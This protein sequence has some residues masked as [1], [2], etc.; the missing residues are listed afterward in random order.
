MQL[1][2]VQ[3]DEHELVKLNCSIAIEVYF[4]IELHGIELCKLLSKEGL[5]ASYKF[6]FGKRAIHVH[7][8]LL[9]DTAVVLSFLL[10]QKLRGDES[11]NSLS[12]LGLV[13]E[14]QQATHNMI[15]LLR[16]TLM[17]QLLFSNFLDPV[18]LQGLHCRRS[19]LIVIS[20]QVRDEIL[21]F[22]G[23]ILPN[24]ILEVILSYLYLF[25]YL[26]IARI[27]ERRSPAK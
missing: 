15:H 20:E 26:F 4:S 16:Q 18:M 25:H 1:V 13:P 10:G 11:V 22:I 23:N 9:E 27:I 21:C 12:Q 3:S 7:V 5:G 2:L 17:G 19:L 24:R 8:E 6:V 14:L